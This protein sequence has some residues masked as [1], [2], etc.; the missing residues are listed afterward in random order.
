MALLL[1]M[2]DVDTLGRFLMRI[3]VPTKEMTASLLLLQ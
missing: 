1:A 3:H 2:Q